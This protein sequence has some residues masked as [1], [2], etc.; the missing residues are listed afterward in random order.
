MGGSRPPANTNRIEEMVHQRPINQRPT[1]PSP[2]FYPATSS[3]QDS[4]ISSLV[5]KMLGSLVSNFFAPP[6]KCLKVKMFK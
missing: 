1:R 5:M 6:G 3:P 2:S 4:T